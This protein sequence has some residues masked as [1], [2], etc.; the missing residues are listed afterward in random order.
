MTPLT[1]QT[2]RSP[3]RRVALLVVVL[4]A[5]AISR[6]GAA[7]TELFISEYVEGSSNN[8]AIEIYNGTGAPVNLATGNYVV[9][10][11]FNGSTTAGLTIPLNGTIADGDVYVLAQASANATIL[12]QADQTNGA[13]W[14]NGD[15]AVVLRRGGATGTIVDAIGQIGFDPGT[16]WGS[17]LASTADNTLRRKSTICLGDPNGSDVFNPTTEWDGFAT[18]TFDGLGSHV[19][20]CAGPDAAPTVVTTYPTDGATTVPANANLSV[21]FSEPVTFTTSSFTLA[22]SISGMKTVAVSGGPTTFAINPDVDFVAGE[23]CTFTILAAGVSDT[24]LNDPPDTMVTNFVVS[25]AAFDACAAPYT[26]TWQIQGSG[27]TSPFVGT[28]VTTR[29][30]VVGDYEGPSPTLRGFYIQDMTGDADASTSDAV[31][32]FNGSNNSVNLGDVVVVTGAV[33]EFQGQTQVSATA[34]NA[35]GT[36]TLAPV[37]VTLPLPSA[38]F[39]ER[40]EGMLVRLPQTLVVTEHF[41]LGRFG[42]VVVSSGAR[43]RQ[44][45]D[46][47]APGAAAAALQAAND[48]N[49]LII[50]DGLNNQN[51]DP[52]VFGRGGQPLS[53]ANTLRAGDTA[54]NTVG[55]M[56]Y[57]WAGSS[58][59]G[60]AYRVR[61]LG[62]LGGV[63]RFD[64]ANPRPVAA[65]ATTGSLRVASMNLLNFFNTFVGCTNGVGGAASDDNCRGADNATEFGRQWPK[66]LDAILGTGADVVGVIEVE[67]DGYGPTSALQ[68][69]VDG[70]NAATAPGTWA[71]IDVDGRTGQVNALGTDAIK[72]GLLY[73]PARVVPVGQT[74]A[75]NSVEFVNGGDLAPRNRP[76]LA[77]AFEQFATGARFVVSVNHLKSKGSACGVPDAGDGQGN[78]NG[79]RTTASQLLAA[80]LAA[81][82][83]GT[84]DPDVLI[85]GDLNAYGME[86]PV[87]AL[88]DASYT[89]LVPTFG[90]GYSYVFD[91]Q[92]GSL[93]HALASPGLRPQ[94]TGAHDWYINADEPSVLDYNTDF[95][96]A[97]QVASLYAPDRFRMSDHNPLLVDLDLVSPTD[98][99]AMVN[100]AGEIV[101]WASGGVAAGDAGSEANFGINVKFKPRST[102]PE[103]HVNLVL[104]RTEVD[105]V[106]TYQ[107]KASAITTLLRDVATGQAL[108]AARA[109]ISDITTPGSPVVI[110]ANAILR[111]TVDDN[112][113][114]GIGADTIGLTVLNSANA[115]WFS[116]NGNG[117]AVNQVIVG[118]NLHV[119]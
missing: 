96:S 21:T 25:F 98:T 101:L 41:Q 2:H 26:P 85:V 32:V 13:G 100:G 107:V 51:P 3:A 66:T 68:F 78:C 35:C 91:G 70:L 58:A 17:G 76:S 99:S 113:N 64:A 69:L 74:A 83:T 6:P 57:T 87:R 105:G 106:H 60:N 55:V 82:P 50:D 22:C 36:A 45:T 38:D 46:V 63:V 27:A 115:L 42:Q 93:D 77:Q 44:P 112:G 109:T 16:E 34:V 4:L 53:A 90:G 81:D 75:L 1:H 72:V 116:S 110:D 94:V 84:G 97:G 79:V 73:Q 89:N 80:W 18:D 65:P 11:F 114:P 103:G 19:A 29:G 86:D 92:W 117:P 111:V 10:M 8:K 102:A 14:F 15:D 62:A 48:L 52:I 20:D 33:A 28:T 108:I 104:R 49:Q 47:V 37:D 31:F 30:V 118:G 61:P 119:R 71:L 12:A 54:Q 40:Y 67:N 95:K 59:S 7:A 9:Q 56:T 23:A 24:D 39:L 5:A 43:L 88:T